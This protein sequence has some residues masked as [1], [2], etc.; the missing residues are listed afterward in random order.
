LPEDVRASV[1]SVNLLGLGD[2]ANFAFHVANWVPGG[3]GRGLPVKPEVARMGD[4]SVLCL[5]GVDERESPCPQLSGGHVKTASLVGGHHFGGDYGA[6][7]QQIIDHIPHTNRAE[8][9]R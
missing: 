1:R 7:V 3:A 6:V 4:A 5:Y 8:G 2:T 9:M